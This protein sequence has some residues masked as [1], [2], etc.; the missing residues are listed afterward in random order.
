M[1]FARRCHLFPLCLALLGSVASAEPLKLPVATPV[2]VAPTLTLGPAAAPAA[3]TLTPVTPEQQALRVAAYRQVAALAKAGDF[4]GAEKAITTLSAQLPGGDP[5]PDELRGT[6]LA[7][8]KDYAAA[9]KAFERVLAKTPE[10][11]INR[12][13]RAE[14]IFLQG[15]YAQ[16]GQLFS[17]VED[18]T[19]QRDPAV[20]DLCRFKR[21]LCLLAEGKIPAA[22][23]IVPPIREP[24]ESPALTYARAAIAFSKRDDTTAKAMLGDAQARFSLGVANLYTDS[25]V[26]LHWGQRDSEGRFYFRPKLR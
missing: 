6:A 18:F 9:Q 7:T 22:E 2:P 25:L 14:M 23:L 24:A 11:H 19:S 12:F 21:I 16:A 5:F 1:V 10:S 17:E 8:A 15:G 3:S 13:N 4:A 26:E 20:A